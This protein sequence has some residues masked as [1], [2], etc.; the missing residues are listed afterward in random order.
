MFPLKV[1][2]EARS[3]LGKTTVLHHRLHLTSSIS[4]VLTFSADRTAMKER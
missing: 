2:C 3:L 1:L 4:A